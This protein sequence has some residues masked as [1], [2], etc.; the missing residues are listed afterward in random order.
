MRKRDSIS[1]LRLTRTGIN[2]DAFLER[3]DLNKEKK[4]K[5]NRRFDEPPVPLKWR[6]WEKDPVMAPN[7][8]PPQRRRKVLYELYKIN[9][10]K[11]L[12]R[13]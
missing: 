3:L 10:K 8:Y 11:V 9:I 12:T 4:Q 5:G 7:S 13:H 2:L 1:Y 6:R